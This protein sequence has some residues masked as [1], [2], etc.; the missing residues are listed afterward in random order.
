MS[1]ILVSRWGWRLTVSSGS[2]ASKSRISCASRRACSRCT[3]GFPS[4]FGRCPPCS[5]RPPFHSLPR[6]WWSSVAPAYWFPAWTYTETML[7]ALATLVRGTSVLLRLLSLVLLLLLVLLD[8]LRAV[9][10]TILRMHLRVA[11]RRNAG[12]EGALLVWFL[13]FLRYW[14]SHTCFSR[15][16]RYSPYSFFTKSSNLRSAAIC[17]DLGFSSG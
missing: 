15:Y 11:G 13:I 6:T 3:T 5:E 9:V 4:V 17:M 12:V 1:C 8:L 7:P 2:D 10:V 14:L 16:F